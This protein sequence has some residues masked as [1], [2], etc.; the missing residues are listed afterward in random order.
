MEGLA[1][2][3]AHFASDMNSHLYREIEW[4]GDGDAASILLPL[5]DTMQRAMQ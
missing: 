5:S 3:E 4:E 1:R 2:F